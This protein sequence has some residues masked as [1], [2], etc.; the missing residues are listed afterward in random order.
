MPGNF[1]SVCNTASIVQGSSLGDPGGP[2]SSYR[3]EVAT[4]LNSRGLMGLIMELL[5]HLP[6][7]GLNS[8]FTLRSTRPP[9]YPQGQEE[10]ES[11]NAALSSIMLPDTVPIPTHKSPISR[12]LLRYRWQSCSTCSQRRRVRTQNLRGPSQHRA[13]RTRWQALGRVCSP[14]L[15]GQIQGQSCTL[16]GDTV[17]AVSWRLYSSE[18][19]RARAVA[20]T[21]IGVSISEDFV[22]DVTEFPTEDGA[23]GQ[24]QADGIGPEGKGSFLMVSAQNDTLEGQG[25]E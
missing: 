14:Q 3:P 25:Q 8:N 24:R 19:V 7:P 16:P 13:G 2:C 12:M 11:P 1:K 20:T 21:H 5:A 9:Q 4:C 15:G 23:A 22:K 6:A 10:R 18:P 17:A